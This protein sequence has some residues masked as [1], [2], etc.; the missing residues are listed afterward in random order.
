MKKQKSAIITGASSGIGRA[1]AIALA[2]EGYSVVLAARSEK[3]LIDLEKEL[4]KKGFKALAV[5]CDVTKR[6]HTKN[7]A[8]QCLDEYGSIDVL[9]N[10]AGIMPLSFMKNLHQDEWDQMIDVNIKGVLNSIASVLPHMIETKS[11]H[12]VNISSVA[13]IKAYPTAA[14]YCGTKF[15]VEGIT[16]GLRQEVGNKYNI[17]TSVIRPGSIDTH[18]T[19]S[20]TDKEAREWAKKSAKNLEFIAPENIASAIL[21]AISQ[22]EEIAVNEVLVRPLSQQL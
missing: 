1:T 21:Y 10:N 11:G 6:S 13:G 4:K 19:D 15:A 9:I 5:E 12:I 18:L 16:E 20:I 3:K 2:K 14:V 22:P 8:T 17:R 7:M